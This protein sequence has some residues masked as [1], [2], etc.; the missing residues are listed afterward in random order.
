MNRWVLLNGRSVE[1]SKINPTTH[2]FI[3][4]FRPATNILLPQAPC[5]AVICYCGASLKTREASIAHY[6]GG[7]TDVNQ[8]VDIDP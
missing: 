5:Y 3:G 8:Y 1:P 4:T 6:N 7:C 2:R